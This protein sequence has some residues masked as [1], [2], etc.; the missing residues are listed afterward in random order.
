MYRSKIHECSWILGSQAKNKSSNT[1][2]LPLIFKKAGYSDSRLLHPWQNCR[3]SWIS[4]CCFFASLIA[5]KNWRLLVAGTYKVGTRKPLINGRFPP[6][7]GRGYNSILQLL[8]SH[9]C[10][11]N[12]FLL[13]AFL[14]CLTK[15]QCSRNTDQFHYPLL[16]KHLSRWW[17]QIFGIF[18]P[19]NGEDEP[20]LTHIFQMGW[21]NH[22]PVMYFST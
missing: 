7:T 10:T 4:E 2:K 6:C 19:N 13:R 12:S 1:S 5:T 11:W 8:G 17:F 16:V 22:Q 20:I 3:E 14:W 21:F 9:H 15:W 18:T